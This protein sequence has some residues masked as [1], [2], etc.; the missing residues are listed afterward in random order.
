MCATRKPRV[1]D[2]SFVNE[3]GMYEQR[4]MTELSLQYNT[5][6]EKT[7]NIVTDISQIEIGVY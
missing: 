3:A 4:F 6:Y 2:L 1:R 5:K 7:V